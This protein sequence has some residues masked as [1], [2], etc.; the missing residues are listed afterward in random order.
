MTEQVNP[1]A[2]LLHASVAWLLEQEWPQAPQLLAVVMA[3]SQPFAA[4]PSQSANPAAQVMWHTPATQVPA[5]PFWLQ[6]WPHVPQLFGSLVR[7]ISQPSAGFALQSAK[8]V[9]QAA[10]AHCEALQIGV[11]WVVLHARPH[12]PQ[13]RTSF[14]TLVSQPLATLPSQSA[15]PAFVHVDTVHFWFVQT[16]FAVVWLQAFPQEPQLFGSVAI[17]ISQPFDAWWSQS[18]NPALQL[19]TEH[20]PLPHASTA[21]FVLHALPQAPQCFGS[22]PRFTH[23][24]PAPPSGGHRVGVPVSGHDAPQLVPSQVGTPF[25]GAGQSSQDAPHEL[26]ET[27]SKHVVTASRAQLCVPAG[28]TQLPP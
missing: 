5:P 27:F 15:V 20:V 22:L 26:V 4:L 13:L 10:I 17:W 9:L 8:P 18:E 6:A 1:V 11:A 23:A 2:V 19:L 7:S 28:Q 25:V 21:L 16:S 14:V 3:V 12:P 24:A